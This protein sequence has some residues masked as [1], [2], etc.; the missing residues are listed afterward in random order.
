METHQQ[1]Q[2]FRVLQASPNTSQFGFQ[3]S[4]KKQLANAW[5]FVNL[6]WHQVAV[7]VFADWRLSMLREYQQ[8]TIDQL[9]VMMNYNLM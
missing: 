3:L 5:V 6:I 7:L 9:Y 8:R 2:R 1:N 4:K